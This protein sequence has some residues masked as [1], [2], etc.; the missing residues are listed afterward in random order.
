MKDLRKDEIWK[1]IP[2]YEG[3]YEV[4]NLGRVYRLPYVTSEKGLKREG[5]IVNVYNNHKGYYQISL[6]KEGKRISTFVH[7]LVG[8]AFIPN[9]ENKPQINHKN[10]I[11]TDNR[12]ENLEWVTSSENQKHAVDTGL[13]PRLFGEKNPRATL[14]NKQVDEIKL[15]YNSGKKAKEIAELLKLSLEKVRSITSKS[16]WNH[17]ELTIEKRDDRLSWTKEH[18]KNSL[19]SKFKNGKSVVV[20]AQYDEIGN[21]LRIYRSL[22]QAEIET[23]I[24]R[25]S[26]SYSINNSTSSMTLKAGGFIWKRLNLTEE[27]YKSII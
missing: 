19:L 27:Q 23:G 12:V 6:F 9:P 26:I 1:D 10:G 17:T 24:A 13:K 21:Q 5:K 3:F 11:K 7:R 22:N 14:T 4:S 16:N 2:N 18:S 25:S 8:M 20:V 15:L